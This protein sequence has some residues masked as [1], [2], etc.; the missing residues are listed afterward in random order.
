[1]KKIK[2]L[3][4][5]NGCGKTFFLKKIN[6]EIANTLLIDDFEIFNGICREDLIKMEIS[7]GQYKYTKLKSIVE[8]S[9][10]KTILIDDVDTYLHPDIVQ[11]LIEEL[12]SLNKNLERLIVTTHNPMLIVKKWQDCVLNLEDFSDFELKEIL[13]K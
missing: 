1:M 3:S 6:D 13:F 12:I 9:T 10:E 8:K 2:I 5:Y 4:G 11:N 7:K